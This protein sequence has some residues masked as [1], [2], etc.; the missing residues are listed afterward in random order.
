MR[1]I[2]AIANQKGGVGKTTT[3]VNLSAA[4]AYSGAHVVL[5]DM[6]PQANATSGIG[7]QPPTEDRN[8]PLLNPKAP[9]LPV[10]AT[11]TE[12]L[13]ILPSSPRLLKIEGEVARFA[14]APGRLR[15]SIA[16]AKLDVE[17]AIIDC[18]PSL[19][20]I[21]DTIDHVRISTNSTLRIEGILLTMYD[22][23]IDLCREVVSEVRSYFG[24]RV[25]RTLIP[26]DVS[27]SEAASYGQSAFTYAPR[28]P[29]LLAYLELAKEVMTN[30]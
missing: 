7:A 5:I 1:R 19:T 14:D 21:L 24:E 18:P 9:I 16:A 28:G 20:R 11:A 10:L 29:G 30:G 25:F 6:D 3:A 4:L 2:I 17:Y 8:H 15:A 26:R 12:R 22:P 27:L 13:S 23:A